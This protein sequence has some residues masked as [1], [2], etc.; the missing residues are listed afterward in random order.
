M[1]FIIR[2]LNLVWISWWHWFGVE[3]FKK[4]SNSLKLYI[5][6]FVYGKMK[7][8]LLSRNSRDREVIQGP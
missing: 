2:T 5:K 8:S 7:L 1:D 6:I 3:F 4:K